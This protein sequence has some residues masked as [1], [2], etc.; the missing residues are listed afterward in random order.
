VGSRKLEQ[1]LQFA[2]SFFSAGT[3]DSTRC[4]SL[5]HCD[6]LC[7]S[8]I[9][10]AGSL[11]STEWQNIKSGYLWHQHQLTSYSFALPS[12]NIA[13]CILPAGAVVEQQHTV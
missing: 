9:H 12:S 1:H 8:V 13:R 11:D 7:T 3:E 10:R 6:E 5:H 4:H 2:G